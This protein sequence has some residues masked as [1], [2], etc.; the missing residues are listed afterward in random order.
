MLGLRS[1]T[2]R[3]S[4]TRSRKN[5]LQF[6]HSLVQGYL[7][8]WFVFIPQLAVPRQVL[9]IDF[10]HTSLLILV[11]HAIADHIFHGN[12]AVASLITIFVQQDFTVLGIRDELHFHSDRTHE[13]NLRVV[14][15]D[16]K[17]RHKSFVINHVTNHLPLAFVGRASAGGDGCATERHDS[18]P[19]GKYDSK[20][21]VYHHILKKVCICVRPR[22]GPDR[23]ACVC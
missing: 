8:Q 19:S 18:L 14:A 20:A 17:R 9:V 2:A 22:M 13:K 6:D 1:S 4:T 10:S 3:S 23:H 16:R 12:I 15:I 5:D 11:Q 21:A 7:L